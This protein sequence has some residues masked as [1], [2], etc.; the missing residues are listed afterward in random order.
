MSKQLNTNTQAE[1]F[2]NIPNFSSHYNPMN[3]QKLT[4]FIITYASRNR[5]QTRKITDALHEIFQ[6]ADATFSKN[7]PGPSERVF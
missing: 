1:S 7:I 2:F 3:A 5:K 6:G 4:D